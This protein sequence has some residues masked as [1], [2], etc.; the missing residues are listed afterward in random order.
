[1]PP[2]GTA[3]MQ[4]EKH[5]QLEKTINEVNTNV[6]EIKVALLGTFDKQGL[7]SRVIDLEQEVSELKKVKNTLNT[8]AWK[9]AIGSLGGG[10]V[11][12]GIVI[13]AF[14]MMIKKAGA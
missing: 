12:G 13:F 6:L 9:I 10:G 4:C 7:V 8:L 11:A 3:I 2:E 5:E 14:K 1:M